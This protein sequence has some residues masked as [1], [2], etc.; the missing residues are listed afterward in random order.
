M[1]WPAIAARLRVPK[2][3]WLVTVAPDNAP[4]TVPIWGVVVDEVFYLYSERTTVKARNIA[5]ND[6]VIVH[7]ES[8]S[9]VLIV[10]GR[11]HEVNELAELRVANAAFASKYSAPSEIEWVPTEDPNTIVWRLEPTRALAWHLSAM[12]RQFR[13]SA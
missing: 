11:A 2:N 13:W 10:H 12:E 5:A 3:Y 8:G 7:L 6:E 1:E 4:H 9:D